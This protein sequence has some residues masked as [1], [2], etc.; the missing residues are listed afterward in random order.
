MKK[1]IVENKQKFKINLLLDW[2]FSMLIYGILM[3]IMS[4]IFTHTI[5]LD[6]GFYGLWSF[7]LAITIYIL[8]K[9]VKPIIVYLTWPIT[10]LTMGLFYPFINVII[11]NI[12]DLILGSHFDIHGV[13]M[14]CLI[15]ILLGLGTMISDNVLLK[16]LFRKEG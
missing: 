14:T 3:L 7:F 4:K 13:F 9:L 15:G 1:Y 8:N 12:A 10:G 16:P 6:Y 11:L 5:Y 2:L